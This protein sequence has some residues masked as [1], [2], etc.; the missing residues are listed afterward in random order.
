M[1]S[2][3][4]SIFTSNGHDAHGDGSLSKVPNPATAMQLRRH[5]RELAKGIFQREPV[6]SHPQRPHGLL[7]ETFLEVSPIKIPVF[8]DDLTVCPNR[9][10]VGEIE[11]L[12]GIHLPAGRQ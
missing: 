10:R 8:E 4:E 3:Q 11:I 6:L 12:G 9:V 1:Y 7:L 2:K 5:E